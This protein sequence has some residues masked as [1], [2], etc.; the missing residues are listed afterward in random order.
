MKDYQQEILILETIFSEIVETL[1][2]KPKASDYEASRIY[3][4]NT[5]A[6]MNKWAIG[7]NQVKKLLQERMPTE[8]LTAENRP[9]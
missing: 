8:D 2:N 6:I 4:E 3:F 9:A 1:N 5:G 7:V